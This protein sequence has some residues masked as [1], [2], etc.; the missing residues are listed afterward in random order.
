MSLATRTLTVSSTN[1]TELSRELHEELLIR[2]CDFTI[3]DDGM[4]I[5]DQHINL[6]DN[7]DVTIKHDLYTLT[8]IIDCAIDIAQNRPIY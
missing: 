3:D 4:I 8:G 6:Y 1:D 7:D 2:Y 5:D